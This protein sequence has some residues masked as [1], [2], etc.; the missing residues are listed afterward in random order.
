MKIIKILSI[1]IISC[2]IG[3]C[4]AQ[5]EP[6]FT[7]FWNNYSLFNP[8]ATGLFNKHYASICGRDQWVG[9]DGNPITVSAVYDFKWTKINS[10]IGMNYTYYHLGFETNNK[11]NL[12][13]SY[14]L[15]LKKGRVLSSGISFGVERL[16][17]D[18]SKFITTTPNDPLLP[19]KPAYLLNI[20]FG[21]MFKS[22]HLL[23]GISS[24]QLNESESK[25]LGYKNARHYFGNCSYNIN[26]GESFTIK[27]C[28]LMKTDQVSTQFDYNLITLYKKRYWLG[29]T[30]RKSDAIAFMGG[31][32]IK[33]KYRIFIRSH[34]IRIK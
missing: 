13:Y 5:Q 24:T 9:F 19:T 21:L 34:N 20:N 18:F 23:I 6:Q 1:L 29:M 14:Q 12:N 27:P 22:P 25:R 30:Y 32:D 4:Y 7:M 17:Y 8:A 15:D 11:V 10:G 33:G 31:V 28:V 16:Y 3:R 26:I 2:F